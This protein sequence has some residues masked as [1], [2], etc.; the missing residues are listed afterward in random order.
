MVP[1]LIQSSNIG[2]GWGGDLVSCKLSKS[3]LTLSRYFAFRILWKAENRKT[4]SLIE[5]DESAKIVSAFEKNRAFHYP[6]CG[7]FSTSSVS[8]YFTQDMELIRITID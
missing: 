7:C 5:I 2:R 3:G 6:V 1:H 8:E 4:Q